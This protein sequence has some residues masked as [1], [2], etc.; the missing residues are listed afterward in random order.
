MARTALKQSEM[1]WTGLAILGVFVVWSILNYVL[2]GILLT[3]MYLATAVLWRT[4]DE[5]KL[6]LEF[7]VTLIAA[8]CFVLVY[9]RL[10]GKN[11]RKTLQ[12]GL[13]YGLILGIGAGVSMGYGSFAVMPIPY[14]MALSWFLGTVVNYV[15]GAAVMVLILRMGAVGGKS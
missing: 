1:T 9:A 5:M 13:L 10:V 11:K 7:L 8:A 6:W 2:H 15:V 4:A 3:S 14:Y 12:T